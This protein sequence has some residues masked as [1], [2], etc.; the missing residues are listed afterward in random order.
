MSDNQIRNKSFPILF[1]DDDQIVHKLVEVYL[2][3]WKV[4]Y[5]FSAE[6]ALDILDKENIQIVITDINMPNMNGIELLKNI[7][8][9][10]G[11]VQV[12]MLTG[13]NDVEHLINALS[14][15][16]NDFLLKPV[17]KEKI[18]E[19][20]SH[21]FEKISRWKKAMKEIFNKKISD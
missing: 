6:D 3:N 17:T 8:K 11:T 13:E 4:F 19:A 14:Q 9:K 21:T 16:A 5:A 2:K 1:V 10:H 12:I 7:K 18:E 20:L 15:G